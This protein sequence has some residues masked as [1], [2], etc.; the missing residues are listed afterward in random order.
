MGS[1]QKKLAC[2]KNT[3]FASN[4]GAVKSYTTFVQR[5]ESSCDMTLVHQVGMLRWELT[6]LQTPKAQKKPSSTKH[7]RRTRPAISLLQAKPSPWQ[8]IDHCRRL[9]SPTAGS[10]SPTLLE[11]LTEAKTNCRAHFQC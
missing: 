1:G 10:G 7:S 6:L 8:L 9:I 2:L 3:P 11:S 5:E 4:W